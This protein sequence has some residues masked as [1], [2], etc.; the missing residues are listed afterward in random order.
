[1]DAAGDSAQN[2]HGSRSAANFGPETRKDVER[3]GCRVMSVKT[4]EVR[5]FFGGPSLRGPP[6]KRWAGGVFRALSSVFLVGRVFEVRQKN[7]WQGPA[8]FRGMDAE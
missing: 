1:M 3:H 6:K 4:P 2:W 7:D 8:G 5:R